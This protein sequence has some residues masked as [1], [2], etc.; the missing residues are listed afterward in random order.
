[1]TRARIV[2]QGRW[3][4]IRSNSLLSFFNI[5][6]TKKLQRTANYWL[7]PYRQLWKTWL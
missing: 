3:F 4:F 2:K 5:L 6:C 7:F 1:M